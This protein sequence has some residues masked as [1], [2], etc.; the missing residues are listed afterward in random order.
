MRPLFRMSV[1]RLCVCTRLRRV[2]LGWVGGETSCTVVGSH[3]YVR[4][5]V[6]V[7]VYVHVCMR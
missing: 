4:V 5:Y 3:Q 6:I 2:Y 7:Y 1:F